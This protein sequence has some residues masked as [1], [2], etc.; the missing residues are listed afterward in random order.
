MRESFAA[1]IGLAL[2]TLFMVFLAH[3]AGFAFAGEPQ[4]AWGLLVTILAAAVSYAAQRD[5]T[6]AANWLSHHQLITLP[7]YAGPGNPEAYKLYQRHQRR[8]T[9]LHL[10]AAFLVLG[11]VG[12]FWLAV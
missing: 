1:T 5:Y 3:L 7:G 8:G 2:L 4:H 12:L 10:A 6:A 11:A 9:I